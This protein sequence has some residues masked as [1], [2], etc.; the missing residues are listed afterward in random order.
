M[1]PSLRPRWVDAGPTGR[2]CPAQPALTFTQADV[3][4]HVA[5]VGQAEAR[6]A[7]RRL[8]AAITEH[9][10]GHAGRSIHQPPQ[11]RPRRS[12]RAARKQPLELLHLRRLELVSRACAPESTATPAKTCVGRYQP[13][14]AGCVC[15]VNK[16][17][18]PSG[19]SGCSGCTCRGETCTPELGL[20]HS[21]IATLG[22][23]LGAVCRRPG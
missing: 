13:D 17:L 1:A 4:I 20:P 10:A 21:I 15:A 3:A 7:V 5:A 6:R 23:R 16:I 12:A 18:L 22:T 11:P 8:E 9:P 14:G 19:C 2:P